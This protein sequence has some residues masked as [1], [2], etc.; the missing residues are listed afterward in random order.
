MKG[1]LMAM[2]SAS[3]ATWFWMNPNGKPKGDGVRGE[4][5]V[6][7]HAESLGALQALLEERDQQLVDLEAGRKPQP[8]KLR[9]G[10]SDWRPLLAAVNA[11]LQAACRCEEKGQRVGEKSE[12]KNDVYASRED[13]GVAALVTVPGLDSGIEEPGDPLKELWLATEH[14][15][16]LV[17]DALRFAVDSMVVQVWPWP[18]QTGSRNATHFEARLDFNRR[19]S[20][21]RHG[22]APGGTLLGSLHGAGQSVS[23]M[24][25]STAR[26][27]ILVLGQAVSDAAGI[28]RPPLELLMGSFLERHPEH[29]TFVG[30]R[31]PILVVLLIFALLHL[32]AWELYGLWRLTARSVTTI[33][34]CPCRWTKCRRDTQPESVS[35]AA[36]F[37]GTSRS[38]TSCSKSPSASRSSPSKANWH[39]TLQADKENMN[40]MNSTPYKK[41]QQ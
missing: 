31:D 20:A 27:S 37:E 39:K 3:F 14:S 22:G 33:L 10:Q 11:G 15:A 17:S 29:R 8:S 25:P 41:A 19:A 24:L 6:N 1:P 12:G 7:G 36:V 13:L 2:V 21:S 23:D 34:Y 30:N 26:T 4:G 40:I 18:L 38:R 28:V 16:A 9:T 32:M 5:C 35:A